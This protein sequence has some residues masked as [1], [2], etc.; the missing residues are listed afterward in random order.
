MS[1]PPFYTYLVT[2]PFVLVVLLRV[3]NIISPFFDELEHGEYYAYSTMYALI[4]PMC[5]FNY[6]KNNDLVWWVLAYIHGIAHIY[7]PAFYGTSPNLE[8][9]PLWDFIVHALECLCIHA[10]HKKSWSYYLSYVT[11]MTTLGAGLT[12]H[13]Y[14][15]EFMTNPVWLV[16]AGGGVLGATYHMNLL[17]SDNDSHLLLANYIVWFAPYLGYLNFDWIPRWDCEMNKISL[18]QIWFVAWFVTNKLV[19]YYNVRAN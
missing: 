16:L 12:A 11:F 3:Y 1:G 17:N 5:V 8:Y 2:F 7:H 10:Y 9:T 19:K 4:F 18:F 6:G 13:V 14:D 15:Q